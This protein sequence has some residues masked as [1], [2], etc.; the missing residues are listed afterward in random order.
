[1]VPN[2]LNENDEPTKL[3]AETS[4]QISAAED[5]PYMMIDVGNNAGP[6]NSKSQSP[7]PPC[8]YETVGSLQPVQPSSAIDKSPTTQTVRHTF[9]LKLLN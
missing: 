8:T 2:L 4:H 7:P 5:G 1:M 3:E 6:I 9:I